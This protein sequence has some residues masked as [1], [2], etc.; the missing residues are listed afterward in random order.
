MKRNPLLHWIVT[1]ALLCASLGAVSGC[2]Q[3]SYNLSD[4]S[5]SSAGR[6]ERSEFFSH[7]HLWYARISGWDQSKIQSWQISDKT[8]VLGARFELFRMSQEV[9]AK[10]WCPDPSLF[11]PVD[12]VFSTSAFSISLRGDKSKGTPKG[13]YLIKFESEKERF[14]DLNR[15]HLVAMFNDLSQMREALSQTLLSYFK[16]PAP[17][18]SYLRFCL[19]DVYRGLYINIEEVDQR[20]VADVVGQPQFTS[21]YE[22][23]DG[24]ES[25]AG[26]LT[27]R[28]GSATPAEKFDGK[29]YKKIAGGSEAKFQDFEMLVNRIDENLALSAREPQKE[30]LS[31]IFDIDTFIRWMAVNQLIG[32]W[33]NYYYNAKNY[34]LVNSGTLE[35]PYFHWVA[36]DLDNTFGV[37]FTQHDWSKC[38][39]FDWASVKGEEHKLPLVQLVMSRPDWRQKYTTA[40]AQMISTKDSSANVQ[41]MLFD[42][43]SA[44]WNMIESS[45][46]KE[47]NSESIDYAQEDPFKMAHTARQFTTSDIRT[48]VT[49]SSVQAQDPFGWANMRS[50]H[51]RSY[52]LRKWSNVGE[53]LARGQ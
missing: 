15:L 3:R 26:Q 45:V 50:P 8:K 20:F 35:K 47:S 38:D 29:G 51:L 41:K 16:V 1:C 34:F 25:D 49:E 22:G 24:T 9:A 4:K 43:I 7:K 39:V 27:A 21:I 46:V 18:N 10:T 5:L 14:L 37:S 17:R 32:G 23:R 19:D 53:Q 30:T 11:K 44:L 12:K 2:K 36:I 42:E 48:Q 40:L 33:D 6:V 13:S 31:E 52:I 28:A